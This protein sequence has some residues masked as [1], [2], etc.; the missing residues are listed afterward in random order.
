MINA[1]PGTTLLADLIS[2][3]EGG[4][5]LSNLAEYIEASQVYQAALVADKTIGYRL[6]PRTYSGYFH[7]YF[8]DVTPSFWPKSIV[9]FDQRP[10]QAYYAMA[11]VNQPVVA[12]PQLLGKK[13]DAMTLWVCNDLPESLA[14]CTV[15]WHIAAGNRSIKGSQALDVPAINA[16][17]GNTINLKPITSTAPAFDLTLTLKDR[18]DQVISVYRRRVPCVLD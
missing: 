8:L 13:P 3:Y 15:T 4:D 1:S 2:R 12:L 14:A 17:S 10:K 18:Q 7:F 9:S 16:V 6:S 11:Q 5:S